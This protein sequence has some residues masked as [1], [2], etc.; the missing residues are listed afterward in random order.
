MNKKQHIR[1]LF[2]L[3]CTC[4]DDKEFQEKHSEIIEIGAVKFNCKSFDI[5]EEFQ[6]F[7]KPV[8][9]T[10]LSDY[11]KN[12]THITQEDVDGAILFPEAYGKFMS[13]SSDCPLF[14]GWGESDWDALNSD[15]KMWATNG[16]NIECFPRRKYLNGKQ[17][18]TYFTGIRGAG[19]GKRLNADHILFQGTQHRALDDAKMTVKLLRKAWFDF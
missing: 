1:I 11:C 3:E 10:L 7:V 4:W 6:T 9:N 8:K 15:C 16:H 12:L 17:L 18:Y 5:I 2:D 19:L 14:I 13:W